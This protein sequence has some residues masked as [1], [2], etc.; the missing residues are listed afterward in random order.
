MWALLIWEPLLV[1]GIYKC[2]S[3]AKRP[4]AN[5]KC[6]YSL[7]IILATWGILPLVVAL[8]IWLRFLGLVLVVILCVIPAVV[9][10]VFAIRGIREI[11]SLQE[12]GDRNHYGGRGMAIWAIVFS[13]VLLG[14]FSLGVVK[15]QYA[16]SVAQSSVPVSVS[17]G[18]RP[19]ASNSPVVFGEM[20]CEAAVKR[21]NKDRDKSAASDL[22][23]GAFG[24]VLNKGTYLNACGVPSSMGVTICA[25]IQNGRAIGVTVS[26]QPHD[27]KLAFCVAGAVRGLSFPSQPGLDVTTTT[28]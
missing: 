24:A 10:I 2:I 26:T 5:A 8:L 21:Y 13:T 14:S 4:T 27:E 3:T 22:S 12:R 9:A 7:A 19:D 15:Y 1:W 6:A 17:T 11:G 18:T 25:A 23:A 16:A 28:F 20:S